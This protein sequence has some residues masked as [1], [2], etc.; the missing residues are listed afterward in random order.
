MSNPYGID[1]A[2]IHTCSKCGATGPYIGSVHDDH[3]CDPTRQ[4]IDYRAECWPSSPHAKPP[5]QQPAHKPADAFGTANEDIK[6]LYIKQHG[7]DEGWLGEPGSYFIAG[8]Q[9]CRA[10]F[11]KKV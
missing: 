5:A 10:A 9:A 2:I 11:G 4:H 7:S 6:A 8:V 1:P 3:E